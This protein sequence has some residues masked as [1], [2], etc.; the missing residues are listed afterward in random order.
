M[1]MAFFRRL[2]TFNCWYSGQTWSS[3]EGTFCCNSRIFTSNSNCLS[4]PFHN[5]TAHQ[6][7]ARSM[8]PTTKLDRSQNLFM[9]KETAHQHLPTGRYGWADYNLFS[10]CN[11]QKFHFE[12]QSRIG[13]DFSSCGAFTVGQVVRKEQLEFVAHVHVL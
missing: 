10:G 3:V 13:F 5:S 12:D 4:Y 2:I 11:F 6:P 9:R 8:Y 1:I 7:M